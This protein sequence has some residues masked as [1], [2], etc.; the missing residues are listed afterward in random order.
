MLQLQKGQGAGASTII[1][2]TV[3][4]YGPLGMYRGFSVV[5]VGNLP[6]VKFLK[7]SSQTFSSRDLFIA[8]K[9]GNRVHFSVVA[10]QPT[11]EGAKSATVVKG[12]RKSGQDSHF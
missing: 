7:I 3:R 2:E 6:K 10:T 1:R 4:Q 11:L 8:S 5:L 9:A 12:Q